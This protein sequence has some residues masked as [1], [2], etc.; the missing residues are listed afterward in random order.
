MKG[1]DRR[2]SRV[3]LI[4][5]ER[6]APYRLTLLGDRGGWTNQ[7]HEFEGPGWVYEVEALPEGRSNAHRSSARFATA[8][9][10]LEACLAYLKEEQHPVEQSVAIE[11]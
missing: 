4:V 1:K 8:G 6:G 11:D 10:A 5:E 3:S 2:I 9:A 7:S